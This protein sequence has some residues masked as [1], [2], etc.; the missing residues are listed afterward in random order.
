MRTI[1]DRCRLVL[2]GAKPLA[3]RALAAFADHPRFHV[4]GTL[5]CPSD[6]LEECVFPSLTRAASAR[7]I[8]CLG[9]PVAPPALDAV[10]ELAPDLILSVFYGRIFREPMISLPRLGTL[11]LHFG[12]LPEYRGNRPMPWAM[13]NGDAP[14]MTLHHIDPGIDSGDVIA[15]LALPPRPDETMGELYL[16]ASDAGLDLLLRELP[17]VADG[18]A[19]R[20]PQDASTS[21]YYKKGEP[22][23]RWIDWQQPAAGVERFVRALW[24]P[25]FPA[26]RFTLG[27]LECEACPP[28]RAVAG[29]GGAPGAVVAMDGTLTIATSDGTVEFERIRVDGEVLSAGDVARRAGITRTTRLS[30]EPWRPEAWRR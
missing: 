3:V 7:G 1:M 12:L 6:D 23:D 25:P 28:A 18:E 24:F 17:R 30:S 27:A 22:Y 9:S 4:V 21:C 26:A 10:R 29:V 2:A 13:I 20:R 14:G 5:P 19:E 8:P 16:R 11:N 15:R